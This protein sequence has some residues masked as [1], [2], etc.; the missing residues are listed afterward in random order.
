MKLRGL[1]FFLLFPF[2]S[3]IRFFPFDINRPESLGK[4]CLIFQLTRHLSAENHH[5]SVWPMLWNLKWPLRAL[6]QRLMDI[7]LYVS[8]ACVLLE[9][10]VVTLNHWTFSSLAVLLFMLQAWEQ[11]E[12]IHSGAGLSVLSAADSSSLPARWHESNHVRLRSPV[13]LLL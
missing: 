2:F 4:F 7:S 6:V 13:C 9:M 5:Y 3:K 1:L 11:R 10:C 8:I 12:P